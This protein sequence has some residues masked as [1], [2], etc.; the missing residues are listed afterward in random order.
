MK[1]LLNL[2]IATLFAVGTALLVFFFWHAEVLLS[3]S[4]FLSSVFYAYYMKSKRLVALYSFGFVFGPATEILAIRAGAWSYAEPS[5]FGIPLWLP[6][7]WGSA[8]LLL[9]SMYRILKG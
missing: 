2:L 7:L 3:I 9:V 8:T 5:F 6:F 4:L 1:V